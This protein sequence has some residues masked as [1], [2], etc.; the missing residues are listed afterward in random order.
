M[1]RLKP[2]ADEYS[3]EFWWQTPVVKAIASGVILALSFPP[4]PFGF[5]AY[6]GLIPFFYALRQT[7]GKYGF[8]LGYIAGLFYTGGVAYWIG[9]N[10]GTYR[11]A[12]VLSALMTTF[13][14][15]LNF[16]AF[17][18][19]FG[20]VLR[21]KLPGGMWWAAPFWLMSEYLRSFGTLV[22]PWLNLSLSQ[23]HYLPLLQPASLF[24]MYSVSFWIILVNI[25]LFYYLEARKYK[26]GVL[27]RVGVLL[28]IYIIP[29]AYG[30]IVLEIPH[31][32]KNSDF[33]FQVGVIQPN[34]DPNQK[35]S[36]SFR[37]QNFAILDSLT[38][39]AVAAGSPNL[40][41]WPETATPSYIRYNRFGYRTRLE[42]LVRQINR[43]ILTGT[44]DWKPSQ[45]HDNKKAKKENNGEYFNAAVLFNPGR[46]ITQEYRKIKL[47]PFGEYIPYKWLFGFFSSWDLGQGYFTPGKDYTVFQDFT[48]PAVPDFSV[49]IC[50]DSSFPRL[51]RKFR[52]NGA[53]WLAI[54]TNDAWFGEASGPYQHAQWAKVRAIENR[55]PVA[56]SANTGISMLIDPWGR[57]THKL[58]LDRQGLITGNLSVTSRMSLYDHIGDLFSIVF[59]V[60][61]GGGFL[62]GVFRK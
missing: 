32:P 6:F 13:F 33:T 8:R 25:A 61:G 60:I 52:R 45:N 49:A 34:V 46:P 40:I 30:I 5:L 54:I 39:I 17:G 35:W 36:Q 7:Q 18:L 58:P 57:V 21:K 16:A 55:M 10:S 41:I 37:E 11:W 23:S 43:P 14:I 27:K 24:G 3:T 29:L 9:A 19:I 15:A 1:N 38:Q 53:K 47:V 62:W 51:V 26:K 42:N 2:I 50:Y 56:R 28:T 31:Q 59:S 48:K 44:P 22:F 12:A 20:Y 4:L